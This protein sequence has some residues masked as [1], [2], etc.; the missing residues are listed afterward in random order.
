VC[1]CMSA[2]VCVCVHARIC[3]YIYMCESVYVLVCVHACAHVCMCACV[4]VCLCHAHV[5]MYPFTQQPG[6]RSSNPPHPPPLPNQHTNLS[7]V[8][9][10]EFSQLLAAAVTWRQISRQ[11]GKLVNSSLSV[12][13]FTCSSRMLTKG[14]EAALLPS[15]PPFCTSHSMDAGHLQYSQVS[16]SQSRCFASTF[17][18]SS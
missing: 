4:S 14:E 18:P 17:T 13:I 3:I 2:C 1:T 15:P 8:S 12:A 5:C 11:A 6:C 16:L 9:G 7:T 10:S